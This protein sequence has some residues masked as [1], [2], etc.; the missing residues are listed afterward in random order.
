MRGDWS[1][2][3]AFLWGRKV[4][5][6]IGQGKFYLWWDEESWGRVGSGW[7][8]E[9]IFRTFFS[10]FGDYYGNNDNDD[11]DVKDDDDDADVE[12]D[13]DHDAAWHIVAASSLWPNQTN[14]VPPGANLA[15]YCF[16][17]CHYK[18]FIKQTNKLVPSWRQPAY[19]LIKKNP[20]SQPT[21]H[22]PNM[23]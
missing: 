16:S 3:S 19:H 2:F 18:S 4:L 20:I 12:H 11:A 14:K 7:K 17:R 8:T 5:P 6:F 15:W 22:C 21:N 1:A 9:S 13:D 23:F 10:F